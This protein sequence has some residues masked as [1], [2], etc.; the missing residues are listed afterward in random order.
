MN[1]TL[2]Y[3]TL[4]MAL[5]SCMNTQEYVQGGSTNIPLNLQK[6]HTFQDSILNTHPKWADSVK[7]Q[8]YDHK[9]SVGMTTDMVIAAMGLPIY[10]DQIENSRI[11]VSRYGYSD[12]FF[13]NES[14]FSRTERYQPFLLEPYKYIYIINGK[15]TGVKIS[16]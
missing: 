8:I 4:C 15:V 10:K 3:L 14:D 5:V 13:T 1:K 6:I 12:M 16:H 2:I 9:I 7:K 11:L